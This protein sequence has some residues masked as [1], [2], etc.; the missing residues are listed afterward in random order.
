M[1]SCQNVFTLKRLSTYNNRI[2]VCIYMC[3][4]IHVLLYVNLMVTTDQ[5]PMMHI[6]RQKQKSKHETKDCHQ[7]AK[8]EH[9][10]R[11]EKELRKQPENN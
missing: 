10:T 7:I 1:W 6:H 8:K 2:C 11:K 9:K 5:K 3:V 4:Y